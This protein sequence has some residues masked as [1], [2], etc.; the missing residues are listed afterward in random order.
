MAR[1]YV[2]GV[3]L[4]IL[5]GAFSLAGII[6]YKNN[7]QVI[8]VITTMP[9]GQTFHIPIIRDG[10][11][12]IPGTVPTNEPLLLD[13]PATA[14]PPSP[15]PT[16]GEG[17]I[18]ITGPSWS[19]KSTATR[20]L[21][22]N[23]TDVVVLDPHAG[24]NDWRGR[25]VIGGGRDFELIG[26][27]IGF[28]EEE[29][30]KRAKAKK[31]GVTVFPPLTVAIDEMPAIAASLGRDVYGTWQKW[32]REGWKF[33]LYVILSTQSTR[34]KTLGIEGEGDVLNNFAAVVYL[35]ESAVEVSPESV[36]M[37]RPAVLRTIRGITPI[38][39][40]FLEKTENTNR[41]SEEPLPIINMGKSEVEKNAHRLDG[42]IMT[43]DSLSE[44]GRF[45]LGLDGRPSGQSL[46]TIIKPALTYRV[47]HK[48]C[49]HSAKLLSRVKT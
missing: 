19:G 29:L 43:M 44:V 46:D 36:G 17:H 28:M 7:R 3:I 6:T 14:V 9:S 41:R 34:V 15:L 24:P 30:N 11:K 32:V 49:Q 21:L 10:Y 48:K 22:E 37:K 38:T 12:T 8:Q 31:E 35:G 20:A 2:A 40:P 13:A 23:R 33:G 5:V 39:I 18:M 42:N 25:N 4:L 1:P 16:I 47:Q 45:L 27:F 26:K